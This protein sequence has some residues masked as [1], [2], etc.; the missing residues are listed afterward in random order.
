MLCEVIVFGMG[1]MGYEFSSFTKVCPLPALLDLIFYLRDNPMATPLN[2]IN[3]IKTVRCLF[4]RLPFGA[5]FPRG[6]END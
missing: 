4:K 5:F 6:G 3:Q 1:H 2:I